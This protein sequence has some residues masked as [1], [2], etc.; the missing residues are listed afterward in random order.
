MASASIA[1]KL[2]PDLNLESENAGTEWIMWK[3]QFEDYMIATGNDGA[4]E[5]VKVAILRNM[6]GPEA[7]KIIGSFQEKA[8]YK[9]IMDNIEKYVNPRKSEIL[10]RNEFNTREQLEGESFEHFLLDTRRLLKD[11]NYVEVKEG[12]KLV[13]QILREN[14]AWLFRSG[15]SK[16]CNYHDG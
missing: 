15:R 2:V 13:D 16:L 9:N 4:E 3:E 12:E 14:G 5:R 8:T 7:S 1:V 6:M 10:Y 11:A